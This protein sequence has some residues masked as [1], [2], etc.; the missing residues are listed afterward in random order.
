[1][2]RFMKLTLPLQY[3]A[4]DCPEVRQYPNHS[5]NPGDCA[6]Q[7]VQYGPG[8]ARVDNNILKHITCS[9]TV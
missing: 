2:I 3:G 1:M 4:L 5:T 6:H 9:G 7:A 8:R